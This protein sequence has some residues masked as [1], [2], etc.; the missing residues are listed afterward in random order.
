MEN[1]PTFSLII[2]TWNSWNDLSRCLHSI[3]TSDFKDLEII[4]IDNASIDNTCSELQNSYP[5]VILHKNP[6]NV[7]HA[8]GVNQ[9]FHI[10]QGEYVMVLDV[11]TELPANMLS[12]MLEFMRSHP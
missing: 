6:T 7:G 4:V 3:F 10:V 12:G 9:G 2:V 11:D 1:A 8:K 5:Q